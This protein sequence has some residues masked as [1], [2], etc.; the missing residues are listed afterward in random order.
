MMTSNIKLNY[1]SFLGKNPFP[2]SSL[3]GAACWLLTLFAFVPLGAILAQPEAFIITV[4]TDNPGS[5]NSSSFTIPTAGNGYDYEVDWDNNGVYDQ[6]GIKG[7]VTHNYQ[8]PGTYTLRIKGAFPR[9]Y[10]NNGGDSQK[11][12]DVKQWGDIAWASMGGA[13]SGCSNLNITARDVPNLSAVSDMSFMFAGCFTLNGPNN[14]GDWNTTAV[15]SMNLT[16]FNARAFNQPIGN[17]NTAAVTGMAQMFQGAG[18]FN[19]PIGNW[20]TAKVTTMG[21]MFWGAHAFNQP[22][23]NWNTAS[24]TD[25]SGMFGDARSFNQPI[26]NWNT[27]KVKKMNAMFQSAH[28]FNQPVGNWNTAAVTNMSGMFWS[29]RAFN[30]PV[31]NWNTSAVTDMSSLFWGAGAFNQPIGNWKLNAAVNM[32]HMLDYCGM[33]CSNYDA[34]LSGWAGNSAPSGRS[35][36][37]QGRQ[38]AAPSASART[39]LVTTKGWT[40]N[41]DDATGNCCSPNLAQYNHLPQLLPMGTEGARINSEIDAGNEINLEVLFVD[42][43]DKPEPATSKDFDG[44]W[45]IISSNGDLIKA[46]KA[47]GVKVNVNLHKNGWKR[48]PNKLS[49]YFPTNTA[50]SNWKWEDYTNHSSKLLGQ[51]DNYSA[52]TILVIVPNKGLTGFKSIPSGAHGVPGHFR[53]IRKMITLVPNIYNEHYT[54][55]MHE[56]GHCFGSNELYPANAPYLHEVAGY[57]LMGDVVYATG[58][59]GWHR[60]RYG[61][62]A[63]NRLQFLHQKGCYTIDLKKISS[64]S[65]KVMVTIPDP[66][67]LMKYWVVEI[68]QD[69]ISRDQYTAK[70][71]EKLNAEGDRLIVYTVEH[72]EI[73]GKRAI[74]LVPRTEFSGHHGAVEWLDRVS[75]KAGQS[76]NKTDSPFSF[77]VDRKT[78]DGFS[79]TLKIKEDIVFWTFPENG[80]SA[81]KQ[82]KLTAQSD[83]NIVVS[84][85][86]DDSFVWDAKTALFPGQP[87]L[88]NRVVLRN[89]NI[90]L[91]NADGKKLAEKTVGAP[92]DSQFKVSNEGQLMI[93]DS[94]DKKIWP[95]K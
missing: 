53:G 29:A 78:P 20:N 76:F 65:G 31:E 45:K 19:Q 50:A 40:I 1:L 60:F 28:A 39:T 24:V 88:G 54:T 90:Q 75:C 5:S 63:K 49:H 26:G 91:V 25:M 3:P 68:G 11:L 73:A 35:L 13:F 27:E 87:T 10:F 6:S 72:P 37:A 22:I 34:T 62:L 84:R 2:N 18:A 94:T 30:Q 4:K 56:I 44:L 17:W 21:A 59:M 70:K 15:T 74:R 81:N 36:G 12:L 71:G 42:W 9:I 32:I 7:D 66:N 61:W 46:F 38:Y 16:F 57:D 43:A 79:L 93:V 58:F 85:A 69:V 67:K 52:N 80:V 82:F 77:T 86:S 89:G 14:I 23:G 83:G 8:R 48:M 55:M 47:H 41:G 51:G 95:E 33:D 64:T 92:V